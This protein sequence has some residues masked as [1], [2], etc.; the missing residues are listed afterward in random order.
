MKR[1]DGRLIA[2]GVTGSIAAYKSVELV[3]LL[4]A[5]GADVVV[6]LSSAASRFVG[7]LTFEALTR[8]PVE[9]DVL[10]L[11]PDGRIGH[12]VIADTADAVVIAPATAHFLG[13]MAN[14]LAGDTV[15]AATLATSAPVV[16][17]PAMDGDMW[18]HP[19][20]R[21]NVARLRDDF[22][23]TI[24][25]PDVGPL[26]SGQSGIGRLAELPLIVDAV[27]GALADRPIRN[28]DPAA[29]PPRTEA[30]R[31]ADLTGRHV[32]VTAGGTAEP[33]DPVRFIGNR[34]SGKMGAAIAEAA[35][36]RGAR[37]TLV[38]GHVTAP[39]PEAAEI[40]R[41]ETTAEMRD[42]V[43]DLL[44][45]S[46]ALVM[47]AA[48]ADFRPRRT[49]TSKLTRDQALTI[50]LE[51]T[52]DI[53][54]G[55]A[56]AVRAPGAREPRPLLVGFAAETG[57]L[58]RAADK[59]RRKGVDLLVAND[60]SEAGSGFGTD[61]N[62]VTILAADGPDQE[63]PLLS[64]RAVADRL[65][66]RIAVALDDREAAAQTGRMRQEIGR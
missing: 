31:E 47:A 23:Y 21:A 22:G 48:V 56:A 28:A 52:E 27:A 10:A 25:E 50:E 4:Q 3:R 11:L 20:T 18:S 30:V 29:R 66:D 24:V 51:P 19:A 34:S 6:L 64:K 39:L 16:V 15:T 5:E 44:D 53:L 13:A 9:S 26:A 61:T 43:L 45:R 57:S 38:V 63:L 60:V 32:L 46:D 35:L 58:D 14:G 41:V 17:A 37:V 55:A 54:A 42:A 40:I 33:I 62:R 59:L 8:H 7:S 65:L 2:V 49:A 1:L 36:D 12:I